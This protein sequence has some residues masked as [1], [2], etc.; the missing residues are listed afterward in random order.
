MIHKLE[1]W[2]L[3]YINFQSKTTYKS[4]VLDKDNHWPI[5][6]KI[7]TMTYRSEN[8]TKFMLFAIPQNSDHCFFIRL[9]HRHQVIKCYPF[10]IS[11]RNCSI[12]VNLMGIHMLE[13]AIHGT[14]FFSTWRWCSRFFLKKKNNLILLFKSRIGRVDPTW[15]EENSCQK[16]THQWAQKFQTL[17]PQVHRMPSDK[18][19][20]PLLKF[21]EL[22]HDKYNSTM[23]QM[24]HGRVGFIHCFDCNNP[25]TK[26]LMANHS[27]KNKNQKNTKIFR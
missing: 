24:C 14:G 2:F 27:K 10:S 11:E 4:S 23:R 15:N 13:K 16:S 20:D 9:L 6:Q 18:L 8:D 21:V 3:I 12:Y 1:V 19:V 22:E 7:Y 26:L 25:D 5:K 17:Q